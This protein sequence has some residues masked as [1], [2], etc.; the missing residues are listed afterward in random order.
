[1]ADVVVDVEVGILHPVGHVETERHLDEAPAERG[2]IVDPLEDEALGR[3]Q[4]AAAGRRGRVVE[5]Q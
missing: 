3:L 1:M 5:V 4:P 2:Q